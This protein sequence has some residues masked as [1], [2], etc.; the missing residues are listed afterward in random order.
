MDSPLQ[1]H[2][3]RVS[4]A[5]GDDPRDDERVAPHISLEPYL[6]YVD[7]GTREDV[8]KFRFLRDARRA[9]ESLPA[10][11]LVDYP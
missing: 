4:N 3:V 10:G 7:V 2:L 11:C 5:F 9:Y 6:R 1:I 8:Q